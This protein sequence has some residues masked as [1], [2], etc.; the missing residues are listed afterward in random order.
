MSKSIRT[1]SDI[2]DPRVLA[3]YIQRNYSFPENIPENTK[4][5]TAIVMTDRASL[6]I[7]AGVTTGRFIPLVGRNGNKTGSTHT[8]K[9]PNPIIFKKTFKNRLTKRRQKYSIIFDEFEVHTGKA[10]AEDRYGQ[11]GRIRLKVNDNPHAHIR[12]YW[13]EI[14]KYTIGF[15]DDN[16]MMNPIIR[17]AINIFDRIDPFEL[18][19]KFMRYKTPE[20]ICRFFGNATTSFSPTKL[21]TSRYR[22][23][24][25]DRILPVEVF[26]DG[27]T[28][29]LIDQVAFKNE[30]EDGE[31]VMLGAKCF[32]SRTQS[33]FWVPVSA[34]SED[35]SPYLSYYCVGQPKLQ[36][37]LHKTEIQDAD[38][39][40]VTADPGIAKANQEVAPDRIAWTSFLCDTGIYDQ[41]D[42]SPLQQDGKN[43]YLFITN[44]SGIC[45]AESYI[46]LH[47][48]AKYL[49]EQQGIELKFIQLE[50]D[51]GDKPPCFDSIENIL[52]H[53]QENS[54]KVIPESV[55]IM[56]WVVFEK[57]DAKAV[58]SLMAL[59]F[60][61]EEFQDNP[62]AIEP[63][64]VSK[65]NPIP[66]LLR[67]AVV[68]PTVG[69]GR[70]PT[71][72]GKTCFFLS[73]SAAIVAGKNFIKGKYWNVVKSD[74]FKYRKGVYF[75]FESGDHLIKRRKKQF[76]IQYFPSSSTEK[77]K[78]MD[79]FT[80]VDLANDST[81]YSDPANHPL[82]LD[83]VSDAEISGE[84][85]QP[86]DFVVFD[87]YG[88]L[89]KQET[90]SSWSNVEPLIDKLIAQGISVF[91]IVHS[92]EDGSKMEGFIKKKRM[93]A[94]EITLF[95]ENA[96]STN[97]NDP[98][99]VRVGK[100]RNGEIM[101]EKMPF[102]A[103]MH[104]GQW[105]LFPSSRL[106]DRDRKRLGLK[107]A[108]LIDLNKAELV[109]FGKTA[110]QYRDQ[111]YDRDAI[112]YMLGI[113]K[114][115]YSEKMKAFR[116]MPPEDIR[117]IEDAIAGKDSKNDKA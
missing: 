114:S 93:C 58:K 71:G 109:D 115:A 32:D 104:K 64:K 24:S 78:C 8:F 89:V 22:W 106:E 99:W 108:E 48:L 62:L 96:E 110:E 47:P 63:E 34:L 68:T 74:R 10:P 2:A 6:L 100:L 86:V 57:M 77:Q 97:L 66:F 70:G 14:Y 29:E 79:N 73:M 52:K 41:I 21:P 101:Q 46:Q 67:P 98:M 1:V 60:W 92:L 50:V 12:A 84:S 15:F 75:D 31:I 38:T 42:W 91:I 3:L 35:H 53:R 43:V 36:P 54:P 113:K 4:L 26:H 87:T 7:E 25:F 85:G 11:T 55:Q 20:A 16:P 18:F 5:A 37:L 49:K 90:A 72:H 28:L 44:H 56:D 30:D 102:Q 95:R 83:M 59:S 116:S 19:R 51:Y 33:V 112:C 94:T 81:N 17:E 27:E 65:C 111:G 13:R 76:V 39:V 80:I 40:I 9:L 69:V 23:S 61:R 45:L 103:H 117:K 82:L 105:Q 88:S 107:D